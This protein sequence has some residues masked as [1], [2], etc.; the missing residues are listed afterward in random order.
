MGSLVVASEGDG[1]GVECAMVDIFLDGC[2][3][4]GG[5]DFLF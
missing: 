2:G 5:L 3:V 1:G 4:E